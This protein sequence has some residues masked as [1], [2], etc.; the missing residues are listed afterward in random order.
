MEPDIGEVLITEEEIQSKI[1]ELGAA[2]SRDYQG[3]VP[4]LVGVLKGSALL[5]ADLLRAI[6]IPITLDFIAVSSYGP[7]T[8]TS[9]VVRIL[10]DLDHSIE[11]RHVL[12]IEDIIDT[13]LTLRYILRILRGRHP[14]SLEV[15]TLLDKPA[16]R[17]VD[18]ELRYRGFDLPDKFVVGYGLDYAQRYRN[19]PFIC[20]LKPEVYT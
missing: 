10:K 16:R 11:G 18:I 1:R 8:R 20:V 5:I 13:G 19:L 17:L 6:S 2:I 15:G 12:V 4:L 14:V 7:A 3:R 9:G